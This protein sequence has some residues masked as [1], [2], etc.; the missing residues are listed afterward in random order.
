MLEAGAK[1]DLTNRV[2][3]TATQM[4]GFVGKINQFLS[5]VQAVYKSHVN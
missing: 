3:R 2:G 1:T 4:A 5:H